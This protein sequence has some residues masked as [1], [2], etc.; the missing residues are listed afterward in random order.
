MTPA[1]AGHGVRFA[2]DQLLSSVLSTISTQ[3]RERDTS[4][5]A[6]PSARVAAAQRGTVE[7]AQ[8]EDVQVGGAFSCY[9]I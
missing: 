6:T 2:T 4:F 1:A 7:K 3:S 8:C 5:P 9:Y